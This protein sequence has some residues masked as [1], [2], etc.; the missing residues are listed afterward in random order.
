MGGVV[1]PTFEPIVVVAVGTFYVGTDGADVLTTDATVVGLGGQAGDDI[2]NGG[3]G[4]D[5]LFGDYFSA[6]IFTD[7]PYDFT[8]TG[9]DKIYGGAGNDILLGGAGRDSLF[10]GIGDDIY[11]LQGGG[12]DLLV[13]VAG[14]GSDTIVT[15]S[16]SFTL[17]GHFENLEFSTWELDFRKDAHG[18]GNAAGNW[19]SAG[20]GADTLEGLGGNDTL[21]G[22]FGGHD[23]LIGG[24]GRDIFAFGFGIASGWTKVAGAN[25]DE[26]SDFDPALDKIVLAAHSFDNRDHVGALAARHFGLI[27]TVLTGKELVLYDQATGNLSNTDHAWGHLD[28]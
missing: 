25:A 1:V 6:D 26:I 7:G 12:G 16:A 14:G 28:F 15:A 11:L 17:A 23:V 3:D 22:G 10:G 8:L 5:F 27:G 21:S 18:I 9:Q 13:E 4:N 20:A 24:A 19:I 2:L